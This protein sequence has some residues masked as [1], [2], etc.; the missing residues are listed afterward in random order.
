[1]LSVTG[2]KGGNADRGPDGIL[3]PVLKELE[4]FDVQLSSPPESRPTPQP[5]ADVQSLYDALSTREGSPGKLTI[6]KCPI[7]WS[8]SCSRKAESAP[9]LRQQMQ[10]VMF[11]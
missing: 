4:L 11:P 6:S 2:P 9:L 3:A 7:G 8:V 10:R 5:A 1:M